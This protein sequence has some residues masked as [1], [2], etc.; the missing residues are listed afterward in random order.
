L[1]QHVE[2]GYS[3]SWLSDVNASKTMPTDSVA[4][5]AIR[6]GQLRWSTSM[7]SH[8]SATLNHPMITASTSLNP[9]CFDNGVVPT[10]RPEP[11]PLTMEPDNGLGWE[12]SLIMNSS[13]CDGLRTFTPGADVSRTVSPL[14][15]PPGGGEQTVTVKVTP[16]D[17]SRYSQTGSGFSIWIMADKVLSFP[18]P[19]D[20]TGGE[21]CRGGG[22]TPGPG[23]SIINLNWPQLNKEYT[24]T[25]VIW[26]PNADD[27]A[28]V[29]K[30]GMNVIMAKYGSQTDDSGPSALTLDPLFEGG[31]T[32]AVDEPVGWRKSQTPQEQWV[33]GHWGL[34]ERASPISGLPSAC[35]LW[36]P[37]HKLVQVATVSTDDSLPGFKPPFTLVVTADSNEPDNGLGDGDKPNDIVITGSGPVGPYAVQLRAERAGTLND[38]V[39][40]ITATATDLA[41]NT[42]TKTATCTVPH[43]K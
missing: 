27:F 6:I 4:S 1:G 23:F 17:A 15:I 12:F 33:L 39:Y 30:P 24:F 41:G 43:N 2:A 36:P 9:L 42:D 22:P 31:F 5:N 18:C 20:L 14:V 3:H 26:V 11:N 10:Q 32:F 16:R 35:T 40:T 37:N 7:F 25:A 8:W 38:R 29:S 34:S 21:D 13:P 28:I 19:S